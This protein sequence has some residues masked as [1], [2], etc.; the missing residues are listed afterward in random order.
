V[1]IEKKVNS[2]IAENTLRDRSALSK[3]FNYNWPVGLFNTVKTK[4]P[5]L[6]IAVPVLGVKSKR[7][8]YVFW[9]FF[10]IGLCSA[11]SFGRS[12]RDLSIDVAE[13]RSK[14]KNY[15]N[16]QYPRFIFIPKTG[17]GFP[18]TGDFVF[19]A[20]ILTSLYFFICRIQSSG[21]RH[22]NP[23]FKRTISISCSQNEPM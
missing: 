9:L 20:K 23:Y 19:T 11:I 15:Q 17:T 5:V 10:K 14:L 22:L 4:Y 18:K 1:C 21:A 3:L 8:W 6:G 16:T 12:W 2:P 7:G 13:Q